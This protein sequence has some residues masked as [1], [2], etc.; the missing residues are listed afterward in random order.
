MTL[1]QQADLSRSLFLSSFFC[2]FS[3]LVLVVSLLFLFSLFSSFPELRSKKL[4][5]PLTID[6][7]NSS[8]MWLPGIIEYR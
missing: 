2:I 7:T 8:Q 1:L 3:L 5:D 4:P 6:V